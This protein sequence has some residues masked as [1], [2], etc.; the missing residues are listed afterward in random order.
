MALS[1]LIKESNMKALQ[2]LKAEVINVESHQEFHKKIKFPNGY[3]ASIVRGPY[4]YGGPDGLYELAVLDTEGKLTYD[5]P[6][7]GDV[8]GYL[9]ED[10]VMSLLK[11]ISE[12]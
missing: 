2:E 4:T 6:V 11:D 1:Q 5:T 7:T 12:L 10:N 3:G 8:E 9:T